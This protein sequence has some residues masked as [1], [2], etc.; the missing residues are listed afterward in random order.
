MRQEQNEINKTREE[1]AGVLADVCGTL[2]LQGALRRC[3]CRRACVQV[4]WANEWRQE[5]KGPRVLAR[6]SHGALAGIVPPSR[7]SIRE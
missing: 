6:V 3:G 2:R 5:Q 1:P 4:G 7:L